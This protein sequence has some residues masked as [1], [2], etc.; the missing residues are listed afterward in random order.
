MPDMQSAELDDVRAT[1]PV[2]RLLED[3]WESRSQRAGRR[4][5]AVESVAAVSFLGVAVALAVP[6]LAGHAPGAALVA[7]LIALYA[8]VAG[9]IRFPLGAGYIVPSY[10]VLVPMLVLLPPRLVPLCTAAGL[11]LASGAQWAARRASVEHILRSIPNAWYALG[12]TA[13]IMVAGTPHATA[14]IGMVFVGAFLAGC[15][16]DLAASTVRELAATAVTPEVQLQVL[17]K[18]WLI[19]ACIAPLGLLLAL[20]A[21]REHALLLMVLPF[22]ALM[23]ILDRDRNARI[24]QAHHRLSLVGRERTRL[25]AAVGRLGDAFAAK[26]ELP[27]L[28]SIVLHTSVEALDADA[29]HLA[30]QLVN[31]STVVDS[32]GNAD[33]LMLRGACHLAQGSARPEQLTDDGVYV[34]AIPFGFD[35]GGM[36]CG[37]V[38]VA[39]RVRPFGSDEQSLLAGLLARADGA[40][41]EILAHERLREQAVTDALTGLGNR[42]KLN[43]DLSSRLADSDTEPLVLMLFDLD[44]FKSYNDT[45]G[46]LAGDAL[47][48][49]LGRK[50]A[51]AV[52][53]SGTAYRLGGD[54]F[55]A[56]LPA[57]TRPTELHASVTQAAAAL[58]EHGERFSVNAS[59]GAV[60]VPHEAAS[61]E[62]A[63]QL[64]D[65]RMYAR[66]HSRSNAAK[67][68]TRQVLM[69]IMQ[70]KQPGLTDHSAGVARLAVAVGR[71]VGM[72]AEELDELRRAAELHDIGKVGI[73]DPIL[74]KSGPLDAE[75]WA[76]IRQHTILGERILSAAPAL[77]PVA[78]VVRA[79]HERW[80]GRGY[81]DGLVGELIPIAARVISVCDAYDAMT[82]DRCYREALTAEAARAE[83]RRE[84]GHQFDPTIVGALLD[85]LAHPQ[86]AP[87]AVASSEHDDG[88]ELAEALSER[89]AQ[90]LAR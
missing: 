24:V 44:G 33:P 75:E 56:L 73:P 89:F 63:L 20:A 70:A 77:L 23:W 43:A 61:A 79:T 90:L 52:S 8:V 10:L 14:R 68:Q 72:T 71:R 80:D 2:E 82:S 65:Q 46:H 27:A 40:V 19:D 85:E 69:R 64:A 28:S 83:V 7:L 11:L 42:R 55:C 45:F 34:L 47:L 62:Y 41:R 16:V 48:A 51:N 18:V 21:R 59:C 58:V 36:P 66:K 67:E 74:H 87:S 49:R 31:H 30:L 1:T 53:P 50:L 17:T 60:L 39:R 84:S 6:V 32:V 13:V 81:P 22:G 76:F 9:A 54:E 35:D 88:R 38:A 15:A 86:P 12:P 29:G 78:H 25:Q 4:E 3:S 26:L 5:I 37:A 57:P